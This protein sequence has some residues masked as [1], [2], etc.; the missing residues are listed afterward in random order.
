M[1]T[2]ESA[3]ERLLVISRQVTSCSEGNDEEEQPIHQLLVRG[4]TR[5]V[6]PHSRGF[7]R[8]FPQA[9]TM[10]DFPASAHDALALDALLTADERG[11]RDRVRAFAEREVAPVIVD[12]W[13]RAEFPHELLPKLAALNAGGATMQGYGCPGLSIMANAMVANELARVDASTA[14]FFLVHNFLALITI[15]LL[16]SEEQKR[17]HLEAMSKYQQVGCWALTEPSNGSDASSLTCSATKVPGGWQLDGQKRWIG[18]GTWADVTVVWARNSE[19]DQV[20]CFIVKKGTPGFKATKIDNKI[21]LRC[22]QNA[23]MVFER[24]FVPDSARLPGVTSFKDTNKVLALSRIMVAWLPVGM[25]MGAYDMAA[26]YVREREQFGS[27]LG[28]FQLVQERLARML[29]NIQGMWM[30]AWRITRLSEEGRLTHE[31]ASLAK[32]WTTLRGRECV[33]LARELLGGNGVQT[34]FLAAKHFC[35]MEAIYTY[36]GTYDVNVLVAGRGATGIAAFKAPK[37]RRA[38]A[39]VQA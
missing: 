8:A 38:N 10:A 29:G 27:P 30:M 21:A 33:A 25:A 17:A 7:M 13:E 1:S 2:S 6:A 34:D 23:D 35:D 37:A 3:K 9:T 12:Y 19:T 18:N 5:S 24:C 36:E 14:T 26:R 31:Q 11:V 32:A 16:G 22:V 4:P 20:N 15:G 39:M 28:S